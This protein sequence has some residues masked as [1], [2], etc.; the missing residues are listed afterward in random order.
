LIP[1]KTPLWHLS[2]HLNLTT[3]PSLRRYRSTEC[4]HGTVSAWEGTWIARLKYPR[5]LIVQSTMCSDSTCQ[6]LKHH[7][8]V[9]RCI[10]S[11]CHALLCY[12]PQCSHQ[13]GYGH[14]FERF[15]PLWNFGG[16]LIEKRLL[17][18]KFIF[19]VVS[20]MV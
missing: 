5:R 14:E 4:H 6:S 9:S 3:M 13:P 1:S 11:N 12:Y 7:W 20:Y 2:V 19:F 18:S 10:C 8:H 16:L 15:R 17:T